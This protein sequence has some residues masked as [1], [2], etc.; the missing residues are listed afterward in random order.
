MGKKQPTPRQWTVHL[1]GVYRRDRDERIA[2][3][4]ELALP[5]IV[6]RPSPTKRKEDPANEALPPHRHLRTRLQ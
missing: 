5:L 6:S 3:A 1:T 2:R 4:Y